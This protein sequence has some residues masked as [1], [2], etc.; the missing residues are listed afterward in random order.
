MARNERKGRLRFTTDIK[1]GV[2]SAARH[3]HRGGHAAAADGSPDLTFVR[4]VA[5]A[6]APHMNGYKVVVH[7]I[8]RARPGPAG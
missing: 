5:E 1:S 7:E 3:L 6:V 4:E 2:E 8:H